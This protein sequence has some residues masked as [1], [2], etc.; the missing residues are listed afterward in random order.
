MILHYRYKSINVHWGPLK[1][2]TV[3]VYNSWSDSN[4]IKQCQHSSWMVHLLSDDFWGVIVASNQNLHFSP[5]QLYPPPPPP[6]LLPSLVNSEFYICPNYTSLRRVAQQRDS[7][8]K[9]DQSAATVECRI[10]SVR[11]IYNLTTSRNCHLF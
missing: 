2:S 4:Y 8:L 1:L 7:L 6:K 11:D 5:F 10:G 3:L 9:T